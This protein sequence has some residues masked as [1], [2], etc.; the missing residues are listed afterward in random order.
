M[1]DVKERLADAIGPDAMNFAD[2]LGETAVREVL[3]TASGLLKHGTSVI[4]EGFFQ[5]DRYSREF[6][7]LTSISNSV[8]VHLYAD[9]S[10]LRNRYELRALQ[11]VRHWIHGDREHL[12]HLTPELPR[13][14]AERLHLEIPQLIIDTTHHP[15]DI[16]A[17][18]SLIW[19]ELHPHISEQSA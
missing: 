4:V 17:T 3:D 12:A 13:Y 5:S 8:L 10:V 11:E 19:R 15:M 14:M 6:A 7:S 1:D 9:D 16:P 2:V 18:V